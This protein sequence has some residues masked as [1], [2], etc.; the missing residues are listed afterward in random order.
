MGRRET[1]WVGGCSAEAL[2]DEGI[3]L[4]DSLILEAWST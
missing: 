1:V 4:E 3:E 2:G